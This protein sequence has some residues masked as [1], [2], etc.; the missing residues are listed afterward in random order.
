MGTPDHFIGKFDAGIMPVNTGTD[1]PLTEESTL[2]TAEMIDPQHTHIRATT[3][4]SPLFESTVPPNTT[5]LSTNYND[6]EYMETKGHSRSSPFNVDLTPG[7]LVLLRTDGHRGK[8]KIEKRWDNQSWNVVRWWKLDAP[9]SVV[10]ALCGEAKVPHCSHL[11]SYETADSAAP[12][13]TVS[14]LT[15]AV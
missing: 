4:G 6:V 10:M 13:I 5:C 9:M 1:P 8:R 2:D 15:W 11:L 7:D 14:T 12:L 3:N